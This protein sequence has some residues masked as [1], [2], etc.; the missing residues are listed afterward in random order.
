MFNALRGQ[1]DVTFHWAL[2]GYVSIAVVAACER[3]DQCTKHTL[4]IISTRK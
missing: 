2:S 3:N 1:L 4:S